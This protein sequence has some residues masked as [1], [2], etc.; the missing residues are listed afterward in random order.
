MTP[1]ETARLQ[2][3]PDWWCDNIAVLNPTEQDITFWTEVWET[4]RKVMNP[5]GKPKTRKQI[6]K[7][8]GDPGSD[9]N[10]YKMWG[11]G[12]ALPCVLAIL[13]GIVDSECST[14]TENV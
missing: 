5:E 7:W 12:M 3:F 11:N 1:T 14:I 2:G 10:E 13:N 8:L 4:H 9:T 6:I